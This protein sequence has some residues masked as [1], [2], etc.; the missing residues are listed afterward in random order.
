MDL[1]RDDPGPSAR[2]RHPESACL[3]RT[4]ADTFYIY[5]RRKYTEP[6]EEVRAV[7]VATGQDPR[8]LAMQSLNTE[9]W[10]ELIAFPEHVV[11]QVLT[12]EKE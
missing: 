1:E 12:E 3:K 4:V 8:S 11:I 9:E 2:H 5:G 6:L 7:E 10:L